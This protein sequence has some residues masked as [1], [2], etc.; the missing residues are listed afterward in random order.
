MCKKKKHGHIIITQ[1]PL[2]KETQDHIK[3]TKV[4]TKN[5]NIFEKKKTVFT[6]EV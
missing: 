3:N 5:C 4:V 6:E 2:K 1:K